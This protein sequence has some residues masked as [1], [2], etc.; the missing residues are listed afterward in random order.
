MADPVKR[1]EPPKSGIAKR[2][3]D[4]E[5]LAGNLF[6]EML[7]ATRGQKVASAVAQDALNAARDFYK[8]CDQS[9]EV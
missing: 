8:V 5:T 7:M 1:I 2:Q 4:M 3:A 6:V 9:P